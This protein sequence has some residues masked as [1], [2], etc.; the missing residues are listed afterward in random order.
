MKTDSD[1]TGLIKFLGTDDWNERLD[2]VVGEH[3]DIAV[4]VFGLDHEEIGDLL[5]HHWT[6]TLWGC[7][8]EDFLTRS[9]APDGRNLIEAYL[10]RRG[11][12]EGAGAKAYMTALR[13]SIMSLYEV[14]EVIPGQSFRARDLIRGGEPIAVSEGSATKTLKQWGRIAARF[15]HVGGRHI[16]AGG[17]LPFSAEAATSLLEVFRETLGT[18]LSPSA[19]SLDDET[20]RGAAPRFTSVWLSHAVPRTQGTTQ[21]IVHNSDGDDVVVHTIRFPLGAGVKQQEIGTRLDSLPRQGARP[22]G[23][24]RVRSRRRVAGG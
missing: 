2:E 7:A 19:P 3:L 17:V 21:P 23:R 4:T 22:P 1:L 13:G 8:F 20:L 9:L 6:M 18:W 5:G 24:C 10:K 16:M 15:A 14:S 11:W 12:R